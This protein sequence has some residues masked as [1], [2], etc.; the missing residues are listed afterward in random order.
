[1]LNGPFFP[2]GN[3]FDEG[4]FEGNPYYRRHHRYGIHDPVS[5]RRAYEERQRRAEPEKYKQ[6]KQQQ[7]QRQREEEAL[8]RKLAQ[9]EYRRRLHE[10]EEKER[11]RRQRLGK[12]NPSYSLIQGP[13]GCLYRVRVDDDNDYNV[14]EMSSYLPEK[15]FSRNM[16]SPSK[17][18]KK[19][20]RPVLM[21]GPD[22]R[23]YLVQ[24]PH[25]EAMD[26]E[27][28]DSETEMS[29]AGTEP[30]NTS[31]ATEVKA[32]S[33]NSRSNQME[34]DTADEDSV[35]LT[36]DKDSCDGSVLVEDVSEDEEEDEMKS[37]W[38]NR[39]PVPGESWM[40]PIKV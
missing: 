17:L 28:V 3:D 11:F 30:S 32:N 39:H 22:G 31:T 24:N 36:G 8:R 37:F 29:S 21:R 19:S 12:A 4:F 38:R 1:M 33:D 7:L 14:P 23:V 16:P 40:E 5:A 18:A 20:E 6:W 13:D 9:E 34:T 26:A 25:G 35:G 27:S 15:R 10:A 2:F